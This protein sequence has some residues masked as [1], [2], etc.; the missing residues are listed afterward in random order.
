MRASVNAIII[1]AAAILGA[2]IA[3]V[4]SR[5][6]WDDTGITAGS[7]FLAA[8]ALSFAR[9]RLAPAIALGIGAF[10]PIVEITRDGNYGSLLAMGIA[11]VGVLCGAGARMMFSS[12]TAA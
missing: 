9:P 10:I 12:T 7:V 3:Y 4:D 2:G 11:I 8:A 6:G 1:T 5:P